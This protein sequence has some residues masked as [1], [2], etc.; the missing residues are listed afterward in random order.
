[1]AQNRFT[2]STSC[3]V[4]CAKIVEIAE[5]IETQEIK[6]LWPQFNRAQKRYVPLFGIVHYYDQTGFSRLGL[7]KLK[8]KRESEIL[9]GSIL[10]GHELLRRIVSENELCLRLAG[11]PKSK[12][13]CIDE[14]CVCCKIGKRQM[15][16]YNQKLE[17]VLNGLLEKL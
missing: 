6:K 12:E 5:T 16:A 2:T 4:S 13:H 15:N 1:M 8:S 3:S 11:I 17:M 7:K 10:E 9:V 14:N